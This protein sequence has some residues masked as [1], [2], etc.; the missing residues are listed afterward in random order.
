MTR[1]RQ[2]G[3]IAAV[4]ACL[5]L[6]ADEYLKWFVRRRLPECTLGSAADCIGLHVAGPLWLVNTSMPVATV[7]VVK[8]ECGIRR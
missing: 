2:F 5:A 3:S 1:A 6:L 7:F 4:V 8:Q